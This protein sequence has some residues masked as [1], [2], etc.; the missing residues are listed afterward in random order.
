VEISSRLWVVHKMKLNKW[1]TELKE[2]IDNLTDGEL[3]AKIK[4]LDDKDPGGPYSIKKWW[5][6]KYMVT[7]YAK[8]KASRKSG[9][10]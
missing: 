1:Q 8:R 7:E 5:G 9:M 3:S 4:E 10:Q 2:Y 6:Y